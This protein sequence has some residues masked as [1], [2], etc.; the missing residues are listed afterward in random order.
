M[1]AE[2]PTASPLPNIAVGVTMCDRNLQKWRTIVALL[3]RRNK[4]SKNHQAMESLLVWKYVKYG[5]AT[6]TC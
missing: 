4:I 1:D 6:M 2:I 5:V 3:E